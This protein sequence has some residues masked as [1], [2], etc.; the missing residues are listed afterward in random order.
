[1]NRGGGHG[2]EVPCVYQLYR[3]EAYLDHLKKFLED[4]EHED[5]AP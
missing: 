4:K 1:M 2:L 5:I 3:P